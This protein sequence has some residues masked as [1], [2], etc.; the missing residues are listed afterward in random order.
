MTPRHRNKEHMK[1]TSESSARDSI[2]AQIKEATRFAIQWKSSGANRGETAKSLLEQSFPAP[3]V[4]CAVEA[5]YP[6]DDGHDKV[7]GDYNEPGF[8]PML[9]FEE[10]GRPVFPINS[11]PEPYSKYTRE[12]A[13]SVQVPMDLP[14]S[15][16]LAAVGMA[17]AKLF[18]VRIGETHAEPVNLWTLCLLDPGARKSTTFAQVFR[19]LADFEARATLESAPERKRAA[20]RFAIEEARLAELR[21]RAAKEA[22]PIERGAIIDEAERLAENRT[23]LLHAPRLIGADISPEKVSSMLAQQGGRF[24]IADAEGGSFFDIVQGRYAKDGAPNM[25]VFLRA[26]SGEDDQRVDRMTRESEI[27]HRPA[28]TMAL[29][30]Q[31]AILRDIKHRAAL[32]GRGLL[33]R[34][35]YSMPVSNVGQRIYRNRPADPDAVRAYHEALDKLLNLWQPGR[36]G[37]EQPTHLQIEGEALA[38]WARFA[39]AT[40]RAQAPGGELS[41]MT[42]FASKLAGAAARLAGILHLMQHGPAAASFPISTASVENAWSLADYFKAHTAAAFGAMADRKSVTIA[43][44]LLDWIRRNAIPATTIANAYRSLR[45]GHGIESS[46]DVLDAAQVL[47]EMEAIRLLETERVDRR[48]GRPASVYFTV[49]PEVHRG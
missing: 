20:E 18:D 40:E 37:S 13:E 39:D 4:D 33:A 2:R 7:H 31:P 35:L 19:P 47:A 12:V 34:F 48:P 3:I 28:L 15:L 46:Q 5:A 26:H 42:F 23:R 16:V 10:F 11:L 44:A 29:T 24:A 30:G 43:R 36:D 25:D 9:Q 38:V 45:N 32:E 1:T 17:A 8:G 21:R 27:V 22:D 6:P 14:G 49:N 41:G